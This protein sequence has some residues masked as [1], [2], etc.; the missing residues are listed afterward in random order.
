MRGA[1]RR[2]DKDMRKIIALTLFVF[3]LA[4]II[5]QARATE[6]S[7]S[8]VTAYGINLSDLVS[9]VRLGVAVPLSGGKSMELV[10]TPIFDLHDSDSVEYVNLNVGAAAYSSDTSNGFATA[11]LALRPDNIAKKLLTKNSWIKSHIAMATLPTLEVGA[12]PILV[13]TTIRWYAMIAYKF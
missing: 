7:T 10:Y 2:K 3:L 12:G 5:S 9:N 6:T 8:T 4:G 1:N 13:K 11:F